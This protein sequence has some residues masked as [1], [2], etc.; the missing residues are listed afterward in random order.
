MTLDEWMSCLD[1]N[2]PVDAAYLDFK[3][4]FDSVPHKR[5][6]CKL[7]GYG[8]DGKLLSWIENFL[9]DRTQYVTINGISSDKV[10]VTSGVPQG[11][12][13]GPHFLYIT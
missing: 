12:V 4:A 6:I 7:K 5:L 3:K 13:L 2:V 1:E 8:I 11:S 10:P 9:S